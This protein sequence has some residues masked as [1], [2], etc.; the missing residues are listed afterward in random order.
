MTPL[1]E[2]VTP[3]GPIRRGFKFGHLNKVALEQTLKVRSR[4]DQ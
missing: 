4:L 2:Q 3:E 1:P